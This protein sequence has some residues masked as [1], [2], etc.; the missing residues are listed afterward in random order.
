MLFSVL[1]DGPLSESAA[2]RRDVQR[3][4]RRSAAA[5]ALT[6]ADLAHLPEPVQRYLHTS[7][8]VGRPRVRNARVRMHGRFR[9]GAGSH[10]MRFT[11]EQHDF[12]DE[13]AR[14]FF[15]NTSMFRC[16]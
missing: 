3:L 5:D 4:I 10:W 12:Y 11:A 13:P 15:M 8:A 16:G 14:L 2:Y 1:G 9:Q 6:T 7:G